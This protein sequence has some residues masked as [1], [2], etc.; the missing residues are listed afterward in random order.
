MFVTYIALT[1]LALTILA[2]L[3][4]GLIFAIMMV[5]KNNYTYSNHLTISD[6]IFEYRTYV[7]EHHDFST[8]ATPPYEVD[9]SDME[10]YKK[11][12]YRLWDWGYTRILP[13]DKFEIIK[14]YIKAA[15]GMK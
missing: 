2:L 13:P 12:L 4:L 8:G 15:K 7:C 9:W 3:I 5:V 1:I 10:S 6:A 14:P 11:T